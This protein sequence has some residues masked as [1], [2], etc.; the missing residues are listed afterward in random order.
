VAGKLEELNFSTN[1]SID[2]QKF[3]SEL[4]YY[5]RSRG[6][7]DGWAYH[8]FKEKFGTEPKGLKLEAV[9]PSIETSG[10]IRSRMI[11]YAKSKAKYGVYR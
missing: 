4:I 2:R 5:A 11:A 3:Y 9:P 10:W 8:K 6:Y 1:K 7:K